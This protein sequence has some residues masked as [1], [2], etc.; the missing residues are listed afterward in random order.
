MRLQACCIGCCLLGCNVEALSGDTGGVPRGDGGVCP[1]GAVVVLSDYRSSQVALTTVEGITLSESFVSTASVHTD[2]LAF[3]LSGDTIVPGLRPPSDRVVLL[4]RLGTNVVTWLDP[5]TAEVLAQLPVGTGFDANPQDYVEVD[6]DRA[7]V[8]RLGH[9]LL[10]GTEPFDAGSDLLI[11]DTRRPA[12]VG[13]IPL[14]SGPDLPARPTGFARL[15][16]TEIA[17]TL[18]RLRIGFQEGEDSMLVGVDTERDAPSFELVLDGAKNCGAAQL[19]P[20]GDRLAIACSGLVTV[21]GESQG[22]D[23]SGVLVFDALVRPPRLLQRF[24]AE[25]FGGEPVQYESAFASEGFLL[26]KTQTPVG[27]STRNRLLSLE[28]ASGRVETLVESGRRGDGLT[29]GTV[30]CDP[31][32]S[33]Y[34]LVPDAA[35]GGLQRVRIRDDGSLEYLDLLTVEDRVGL[36][37]R[38]LAYR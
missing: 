2:G 20:S 28:L 32:C 25:T 27:G 33:N 11:I 9:N 19:S 5:T 17:V 29:L 24:E 8:S 36:P 14:P 10:A 23:S 1:D 13:S 16:P 30:A 15:G 6:A 26:L 4:D 21:D 12:I 38:R 7:Y 37:P 35:A 34:C 18:T 22:L 31:G 3:A